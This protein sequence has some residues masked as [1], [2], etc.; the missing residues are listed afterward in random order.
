MYVDF[1]QCNQ[2]VQ[3]IELEF[4]I[5]L[6]RLWKLEKKSCLLCVRTTALILFKVWSVNSK[7]LQFFYLLNWVV[8]TY[9]F[10]AI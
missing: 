3:T 8:P 4:W 6:I 10:I 7:D 1:F 2:G 5:E 9:F